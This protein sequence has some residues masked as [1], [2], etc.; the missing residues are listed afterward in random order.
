MMKEDGLTLSKTVETSGGKIH[1]VESK[2]AKDCIVFL[3]GDSPFKE[4][5]IKQ[6]KGLGEKYKLIAF[7]LPGHSVSFPGYAK[8]IIEALEKMGQKNITFCDWSLGGH[9]VIEILKERPDLVSKVMIIGIPQRDVIEH[10]SKPLAIIYGSQDKGVNNDYIQNINYNENL[11]GVLTLPCGH[12]CHWEKPRE[13]NAYLDEFMKF[14]GFKWPKETSP[15]GATG[16]E[17]G[18]K[19]VTSHIVKKYPL[20]HVE[21]NEFATLNK[22][23][24]IMGNIEPF[25][26]KFLEYAK[27]CDLPVLSVGEGSGNIVNA[28]LERGITFIANDM[29]VRHLAHL[30]ESVPENKR[31][32]LFLKVGKFPN[33]TNLPPGGLGAIYFG[34]ILHFQTG[35][36]I[37]ESLKAAYKLLRKGGKVFARASTPFQKH[38]GF[39]IPTYEKR[40]KNGDPWPGMCADME[41][42]W[43]TLH[44]YLPPLMHLLDINT[45]KRILKKTGFKIEELKYLPITHP[46]F[47]LDGREGIGFVASK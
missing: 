43:P 44:Q 20:T 14:Q 30:Y 37:E 24:T 7:D 17:P 46:E 38:L 33:E 2:G 31:Q 10:C 29:D 40:I 19:K 22:M 23:G 4:V 42:G 6:F 13:F 12:A 47:Q 39:F 5:F 34:R 28:A 9:I 26:M 35:K 11:Y 41:Q 36:E 18:L 3:Q 27:T 45:L 8:I 21:D 16:T 1:Y 15:L 25:A 32:F